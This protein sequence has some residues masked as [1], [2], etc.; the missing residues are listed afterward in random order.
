MKLAPAILFGLCACLGVSAH[1]HEAGQAHYI[2]NEG[3]L[4]EQGDVKILFDPLPLSGFNVYAE[5]SEVQVAAMMAGEGAF[6]GVDAVFISHA[7]RDHFSAPS[8]VALMEAQTEI[9]LI[10]PQQ[11]LDMMQQD[12]SWSD[13][14]L[15]RITALDMAAGDTPQTVALEGIRA[16]ALRIPHAGWPAPAR[17]AVQNMVYRVTLGEAATVIHMGDADT[18]RRHFTPH[19]THWDARRTDTAFPPYWFLLS[20]DGR[21]ILSNDMNVATSIGV[22]VPLD[23]PQDLRD[24]GA[25]YFSIPGE[26]RPI[27]AEPDNE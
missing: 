6:A 22:H 16:T 1:A 4:V 23:V 17:A 2:A 5:P 15:P 20:E 21:K 8:V 7:H 12:A 19:K 14:L 10:A 25:D 26:T 3:V 9:H 24:S 27:S 11:A 13:D 18:R